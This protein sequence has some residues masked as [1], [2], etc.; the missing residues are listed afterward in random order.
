MNRPCSILAMEP[1]RNTRRSR[2]RSLLAVTRP[3]LS[4]GFRARQPVVFPASKAL[5]G[6][7]GAAP[8]NTT[9][10]AWSLMLLPTTSDLLD[11]L[12][13]VA[14]NFQECRPNVHDNVSLI[15]QRGLVSM[16]SV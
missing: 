9:G 11:A 13:Y 10:S 8:R 14:P 15:V 3:W 2:I 7:S 5:F 12:M 4:V 1:L 16:V 6:A